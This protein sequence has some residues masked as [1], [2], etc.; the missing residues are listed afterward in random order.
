[1]FVSI[2]KQIIHMSNGCLSSIEF[3]KETKMEPD[4]TECVTNYFMDMEF[5]QSR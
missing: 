1:M 4:V 5:L 2:V 3:K